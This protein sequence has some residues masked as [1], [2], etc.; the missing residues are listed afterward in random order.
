MARGIGLNLHL[1][2]IRIFAK[3]GVNCRHSLRTSYRIMMCPQVGASS[4]DG[5]GKGTWPEESFLSSHHKAKCI[6]GT[7]F[8]QQAHS[9]RIV[10]GGVTEEVRLEASAINISF[11]DANGKERLIGS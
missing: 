1:Q 9:K 5:C 2:L 3:R 8:H 7:Q 10:V 4:L 6:R 11:E